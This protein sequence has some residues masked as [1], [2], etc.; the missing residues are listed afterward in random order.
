MFKEIAGSALKRRALLWGLIGS[1]AIV[2]A[3][4]LFVRA[5]DDFFIGVKGEH[6]SS[7]ASIMARQIDA[8]QHSQIESAEDIDSEAY[9]RISSLLEKAQDYDPNIM[10]A[11]TL[12]IVGDRAIFIVSPPADYNQDGKIEGELEERDPI[13][14]PYDEPPDEAMTS[15]A[16]VGKA[17]ATGEFV[18]DK[19]GTWL[20]GCAPL[21]KRSGKLDGAV[22]LDE[23]QASVKRDMMFVSAMTAALST[24]SIILLVT[25]IAGYVKAKVSLAS[26]AEAERSRERTLRR[27]ESAI[28]NA[29]TVGVQAIDRDGTIH[30][31]NKASRLIFGFSAKEAAG[32]K[33]QELIFD[34]EGSA[35]F[36]KAI[37]KICET[38]RPAAAAEWTAKDR[39]GNKHTILSTFFPIIEDGEITEIFCVGIDTT[40]DKT[41]R[42]DLQRNIDRL[43]SFSDMM[44][45]RESR[46]LELK[47]E[48]NELC[49]KL[50]VEKRYT[51]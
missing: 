19:W 21:K 8:E 37:S 41:A 40:A 45:G 12:R 44:V 26:R 46:M 51:I 5:I 20:T 15:A 42:E 18:E 1:A 14:T 10:S 27:F 6:L 11:Y 22:C 34:E 23:D 16:I 17:A 33:L 50:G 29:P 49:E 24:F 36:T 7:L 35:R 3:N 28:E 39:D 2:A 9:A 13:G 48:I 43:K 32:K 25:S 31:W 38:K 4:L 30:I 47:K